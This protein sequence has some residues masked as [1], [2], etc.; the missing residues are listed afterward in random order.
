MLRVLQVIGKMDRAGAETILMN[1]YR[2][3]D[4]S[5]VQ[6]D[7]MV[8]S[9]EKGDYDDEIEELGG[10]IYHMPAFKGYNYFM[11]CGKFEK[12]FKRHPYKIVHGHIGSLAPAYLKAAKKRGAYVIA[13]SHATKSDRAL[14]NFVFNVFAY[15]V[16]YIADYFF[17][18]SNQAGI[19][20]FG[21]K[22]VNSNRF[23]VIN[24]AIDSGKYKYTL[25]RHSELKRK[26]RL[27]DKLVIGHVGRFAPEKNHKFIVDVFD[28]IYRQEK[29]AVL[30]LAGRGSEEETIKNYVSEKNLDE[31]VVF[32]G[33]RKDIPDLMNLFDVFLFPS[34]Y[35]GL[36]I[37][38]I[39]A[40]ASGLPTFMS[41]AVPKEAV[42]TPNA[43]RYSVEK[44]PIYWKEKIAEKL[45]NFERKDRQQWIVEN[46]YDIKA[47]AKRMELFYRE[48][49]AI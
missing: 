30:M 22:V 43:W 42:V 2:N 11:L 27:E 5:K 7:F 44:G 29:T 9:D 40:Q 18:C 13:H 1:I 32:L 37:V 39:E 3:V 48:K 15:R 35:E 24:N 4:R 23:E 17:A 47:V 49:K 20:R 16:R 10:H 19:D 25:E 41:E 6:F 36:G 26:Y 34:T 14:E 28:E 38:G 46:N 21:K 31:H 12:F 33:V 45:K 8:F